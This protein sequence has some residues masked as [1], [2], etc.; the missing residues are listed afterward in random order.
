[1]ERL[2]AEIEAT[3]DRPWTIAALED[4]RP[5]PR[6]IVVED[7]AL[8]WGALDLRV[9]GTLDVATDGTPEGE[10]LVKATNWREI[11]AAARTAGALPEGLAEAAERALELVSRLAG[12]PDTL[13]VPLVFSDG[14]TRLGPVPIGRA[15]SLTLP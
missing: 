12:S 5:Q 7:A 1:V 11:L 2:E 15:P 14:R 3:F 8:R 4:R 6:R 10:L 9:A 13:D